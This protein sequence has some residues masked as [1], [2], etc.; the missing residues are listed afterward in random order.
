MSSVSGA[1]RGQIHSHRLVKKDRATEEYT[2]HPMLFQPSRQNPSPTSTKLMI[3]IKALTFHPGTRAAKMTD[4]P[5]VPP[6]ANW[7]GLLKST[8]PRAVRNNPALSSPK[9]RRPFSTCLRLSF[10]LFSLAVSLENSMA[11]IPQFNRYVKAAGGR[12]SGVP[13]VSYTF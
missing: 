13:P 6:K 4:S 11:I 8:M 2:V 12:P 10:S 9:K 7:F 5:E 3:H 1:A